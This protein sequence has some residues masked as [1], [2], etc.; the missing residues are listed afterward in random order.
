LTKRIG[1]LVAIAYAGFSLVVIVLSGWFMC[2]AC[3]WVG[4]GLA[5]AA[6]LVVILP[7]A[8]VAG[9][10]RPGRQATWHWGSLL[11]TIMLVGVLAAIL[12]ATP[13]G[14]PPVDSPVSHRFIG[15]EGF[16]RFTVANIVPEIEQ[17]NLGFWV[18][19]A[20]DGLF[21]V[22]QARRDAPSTIAL[23]QEMEHDP[24]FHQLGSV[25]GWSYAEV[26]RRPFD[27]GHYYLYVPRQRPAGPLPV[28]VFL[29]GS[30][31][32]FKTYTWVWAKLAEAR[33]FVI[34]AP[35][36]GFGNWRRPA[37]DHIVPRV[38]DDAARVVEIDRRRI[39]LAGLSN[40]GFG[41]ARQ[42]L[43]S[44]ELFRGLI[45]ISPVMDAEIVDSPD[46]LRAW[47][48]RPLLVL[49]GRADERIPLQYVAKRVSALKTGGVDVT[50]VTYPAEDHF[51]FFTGSTQVL[52][53]IS[54]WLPR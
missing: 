17:I 6:I 24:N 39:Y 27:A 33:G 43:A 47:R 52:K 5:L 54:L 44:P 53:D 16:Q 4:R 49:A 8:V 3:T 19:P 35:S 51:L 26:L 25:M 22:K 21:T 28:I 9:W 14:L 46:F 20:L 42:G 38:L 45:F 36:Y 12:S 11:L 31:G 13:D 32:N 2:A 23:Y 29:H 40:G 1:G 37:G 10:W 7:V 48:D 18:M 50:C 30:F 15:R 34:I 41:V